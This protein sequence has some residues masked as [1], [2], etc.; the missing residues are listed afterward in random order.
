MNNQFLSHLQ[1]ITPQGMAEEKKM[2]I[3][4]SKFE[5]KPGKK[6]NMTPPLPAVDE[7]EELEEL[8]EGFMRK[9]RLLRA[10]TSGKTRTPE[11]R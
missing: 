5:A 1:S 4:A 3:P 2:F 8:D 6:I 7:Q 10:R 11:Q 9:R